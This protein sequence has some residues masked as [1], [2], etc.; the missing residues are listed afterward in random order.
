[1]ATTDLYTTAQVGQILGVQ[2]R[3]V[4][5]WVRQGRLRA[6]HTPSGGVRIRQSEIDRLFLEADDSPTAGDKRDG[7]L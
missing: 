2:A 6:V 7:V 5:K 1:M 4:Q 3:T